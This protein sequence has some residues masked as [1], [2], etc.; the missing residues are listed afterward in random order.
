MSFI[1]NIRPFLIKHEPEILM[2]MG[3]SGMIFSTIWSIKSSLKSFKVINDY[4]EEKQIDKI[5]PKEFIKLTW[6]YYL[7]VV[8]SMGTS[9]PLI[10]AGNRVSSKRYAILAAAYSIS[11]N[12]LLE[13]KEATKE[14]VGEKKS[15]DIQ[16]K[17]D[18]D[19]INNSYKD[20]TQIIMTS[21]SDSLFYEPISCRYFK[22]NWNAIVKAANELNAQ[23]LGNL[24]GEITL[25]DW[26]DKLELER[27]SVGDDIGWK[28][29]DGL[30]S[31]LDVSISS[32]ITSDNVPCGAISYRTDPVKLKNDY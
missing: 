22:S 27:S 12:A 29:T 11:E 13:Y 18:S 24:D 9:I 28:V 26:F 19:R 16:E 15:K 23:A 20:S 3:I 17:I 32:H 1:K 25:N 14:I 5:T 4:K 6:R 21:N 31:L 2:G 10:I 30:N 8:I 7:P